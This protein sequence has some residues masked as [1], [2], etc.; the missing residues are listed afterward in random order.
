MTALS[1]APAAAQG[2]PKDAQIAQAVLAAPED[3]RA[4]AAVMGFEGGKL[5]S[6]R[7]GTNDMV[8][9]ADNPAMEGFS[10]ACYHKDLEPFMARGRELTAQGITEDK[11]RDQTRYDEIKAGK[12]P[13]P[14]EPRALYVMTGKAVDATGKVE[15]AYTRWVLYVPFATGEQLG[16]PTRPAGPGA[17]WLMDPGTGGAHIMISPPRP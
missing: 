6:L 17:P 14:K 1:V 4:G 3:R 11:V 15:G 12:L 16:L 2:V 10:V 13:M 5:V 7:P 9:L 8:C